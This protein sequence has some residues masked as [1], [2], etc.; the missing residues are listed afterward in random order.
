MLEYDLAID[1]YLHAI[2]R[3]RPWT[4]SRE[5]ELLEPLS[6]WLYQRPDL[7]VELDDVTLDV[8]RRY[9]ADTG[10]SDSERE[11]L[12]AAVARLKAWTENR[13]LRALKRA[14]EQVTQ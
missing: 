14:V 6:D 7:S 8:T 11:E 10:L 12:D 5:T 9:A 1:E 4:V 13:E 3:T 2:V